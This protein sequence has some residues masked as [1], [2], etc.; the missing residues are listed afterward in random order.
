M[1]GVWRVFGGCIESVR[2]VCGGFVEGVW[3]VCGE[4]MESCLRVELAQLQFVERAL[5]LPAVCF[6]RSHALLNQRSRGQSRGG[7]EVNQG[8]GHGGGTPTPE[9]ELDQDFPGG[10]LGGFRV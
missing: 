3:R 4:C 7:H 2:R 6:F 1:E 5:C 8:G 9:R 10:L